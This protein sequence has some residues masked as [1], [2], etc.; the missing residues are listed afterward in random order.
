MKRILT[1]RECLDAGVPL[2]SRIVNIEL[3]D[4]EARYRVLVT[5]KSSIIEH[6]LHESVAGGSHDFRAGSMNLGS[7]ILYPNYSKLDS[8]R[9]IFELQIIVKSQSIVMGQI[10][11][12][13]L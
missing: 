10:Y 7:S 5:R 6:Q 12:D 2:I 3:H 11:F 13:P 1:A 4:S 8:Y 9:Y